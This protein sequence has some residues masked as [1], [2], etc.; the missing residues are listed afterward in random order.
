MLNLATGGGCFI[1]FYCSGKRG[2]VAVFN[3]G[4]WHWWG[5]DGGGRGQ[6]FG[7][8]V[9]S[10]INCG[11]KMGRWSWPLVGGGSVVWLVLLAL[12]LEASN[13]RNL[14]RLWFL[15]LEN[16]Y[17]NM[18]KNTKDHFFSDSVFCIFSPALWFFVGAKYANMQTRTWPFLKKSSIDSNWYLY[19]LWESRGTLVLQHY[20]W[21][22][23]TCEPETQR[24]VRG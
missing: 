4:W 22:W 16:K 6:N 14:L 19:Y 17:A 10:P 3:D 21:R 24:S 11:G 1:N 2:L 20:W 12:W 7:V 18:Q 8:T 9:L 23:R 13:C 15:C 5:A